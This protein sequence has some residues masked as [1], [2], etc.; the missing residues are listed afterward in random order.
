V[1][2]EEDLLLAEEREV[3]GIARRAED[4]TLELL[5]DVL[6]DARARDVEPP[7]RVDEVEAGLEWRRVRAVEERVRRRDVRPCVGLLVRV[8][9]RDVERAVK[10]GHSGDE[11]RAAPE[12]RSPQPH[13]CGL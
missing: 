13:A 11:K 12:G 4:L 1:V 10:G 9:Q 8:D 3:R 6:R 5:P 2:A 7:L